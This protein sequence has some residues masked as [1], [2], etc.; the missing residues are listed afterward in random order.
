LSNFK[1]WSTKP[2]K[3]HTPWD[4]KANSGLIHRVSIWAENNYPSLVFI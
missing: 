2:P 1:D 4:L 3:F